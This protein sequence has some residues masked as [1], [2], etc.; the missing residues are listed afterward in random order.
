MVLPLCHETEQIELTRSQA[1]YL[2]TLVTQDGR[3]HTVRLFKQS[4]VFGQ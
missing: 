1:A 4:E 3:R 2:L